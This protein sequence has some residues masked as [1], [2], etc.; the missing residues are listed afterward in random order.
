MTVSNRA[1]LICPSFFSYHEA[2]KAEL[3]R[4]GLRVTWLDDRLS[5][6]TLYK[7]LLRLFPVAIARLSTR[8]VERRHLTL[9]PQDFSEVLV[10]KGESYSV[11]AAASLRA[12][13]RTAR[14]TFYLWDSVKNTNG[15]FHICR[16]FDTVATFDP[17]DAKQHGW[18]Y[19]PLFAMPSASAPAPKRENRYA[20]SFVGTIHSD[21]ARIISRLMDDRT[22]GLPSFVYGYFQ[23]ALVLAARYLTD[24]AVRRI[25]ASALHTRPIAT[26]EVSRIAAE[27]AVILDIEH[28]D[29]RGLTIRTIES[30]LA[31]HKLVTTNKSILDSDLY[32][33]SRVRLISREAPSIPHDFIATP[34]VPVAEETRRRYTVAGWLQDLLGPRSGH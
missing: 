31:G 21:R 8:H 7:L 14:T 2:I 1:L 28:P 10:V 12:H 27:S 3:E 32:D 24:A 13:F 4:R 16:H 22:A 17:V 30:L 25:P 19:R 9:A 29:Q 15:A 26:E 20:W 5:Q 23:S 6:N 33:P 11:A 34:A 18:L